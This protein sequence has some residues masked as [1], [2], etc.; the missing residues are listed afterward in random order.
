MQGFKKIVKWQDFK[1]QK[2]WKGG[3]ILLL[4]NKKVENAGF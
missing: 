1:L 3:L 2:D 4:V